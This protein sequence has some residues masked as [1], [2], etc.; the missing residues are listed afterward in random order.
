MQNNSHNTNN[1]IELSPLQTLNE[2][3]KNYYVMFKQDLQKFPRFR[4]CNRGQI[5]DREPLILSA[6]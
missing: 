1:I 4:T 5:Y 2:K 3:M 6:K